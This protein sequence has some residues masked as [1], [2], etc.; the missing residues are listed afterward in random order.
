MTAEEKAKS[1]IIDFKNI[2][3]RMDYVVL[4][5]TA[6]DCSLKAVENI[7]E[8]FPEKKVEL[9]V[10]YKFDLVPHSSHEYWKQVKTILLQIKTTLY[11][12]SD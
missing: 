8:L 3:P 7:M 12:N 9:N 4:E 1:L 2:M 11:L 6:I 5:Q 10:D